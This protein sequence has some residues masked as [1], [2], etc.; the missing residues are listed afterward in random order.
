M[1]QPGQWE[2]K[3]GWLG[4]FLSGQDARHVE[5]F[6][7]ET[8]V[9]VVWE[10]KGASRQASFS[11]E[12][13]ARPWA[14]YKHRPDSPSRSALLGVLGQEID[15]EQLDVASV[16]EEEDGFVVI[17]SISGRYEKQ[18][19]SYSELQENGAPDSARLRG[20]A[21]AAGAK[22]GFAIPDAHTSPLR[23]RLHLTQ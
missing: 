16:L 21:S 13:L 15:R 11:P 4:A 17:G 1:T 10:Q 8:F 12:D 6:N 3:L 22:P 7:R 23:H 18:C 5:I 14:P 2:T 9:T 19:F 20:S